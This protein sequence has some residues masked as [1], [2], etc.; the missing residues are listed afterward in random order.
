MSAS[1]LRLL[2]C[3]F[4]LTLLAGVRAGEPAAPAEARAVMTAEQ[5]VEILDETVDWY[6]TLGTQ[7]LAATQPSDLL[8][9]YA[10]RQAADKVMGIAFEIARANAE[11]L[12]SD[13]GAARERQEKESP[14]SLINVRRH[15]DQQRAELQAQIEAARARNAGSPQAGRADGQARVAALQGE[16]DLVNARR[17]LL[18]NMSQFEAENDAD[19]FGANSL[20]AH[21][22]AIA[23]SIPAAG[24]AATAAPGATITVEAAPENLAAPPVQLD[25]YGIWDLTSAVMRLR[26]KLRMIDT[27]NRRTADLEEVFERIRI[28][29]QERLKALAAR[30]DALSSQAV[31]DAGT[32]RG[33]RDQ[34]DT[35]AWLYLQTSAMVTPLSKL[36]V[37]LGQYR[38]NLDNWK[39]LTQRQ[40]A[41][42]LRTLLM[43][44]GV[45]VGLLAVVLVA[46]NLWQRA[47]LRYVKDPR[48]RSR[49]LLLRRI[50]IWVL[51]VAIALFTFASEIGSLATF[52]G[53]IT[54]GLAVAM[55]SVLVSV[56][57][58][59]FLVGRY[60]VRVGDRVQV[61]NVIGE[62]VDLGLVRLHLMELRGEGA[63]LTP[64]GRVVAFANSVV[65]QASG[66]LF[67]QI[68]GVNLDWHEISYALPQAADY[69]RIKQ[70]L[71]EA[72]ST[73]LKD[74]SDDILRQ[75]QAMQR[76][77]VAHGPQ[78]VEPQVQLRFAAAGV[79]A[80]VRYPVT[81]QDAAEID[82]RMSRALLAV[83]APPADEVPAG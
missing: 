30:G 32:L 79:E 3:L 62:V 50:V 38:R 67:K 6:R 70:Q 74:Y 7:Q 45:F 55:Q 65:F 52:A 82:E 63:R 83:I 76:N 21:I 69:S 77:S 75:T 72:A 24:S 56:V 66:G 78:D 49:Y 12:S 61:G 57:G 1:S 44:L 46:A 23:A 4:S 39:D 47:L 58:Y 41:E 9:L 40:L 60:G 15:L 13:I 22:D 48:R 14:Q 31:A 81:L 37:L 80:L 34:Y 43:R 10:N 64:T 68:P 16:L 42:A 27:T 53:L 8:I 54:A 33:V 19:G 25:E 35:L 11:L 2:S 5:V 51:V 29:P 28:P 18:A 73:V 36:D 20:K 17:N 59:F 26:S 71:L